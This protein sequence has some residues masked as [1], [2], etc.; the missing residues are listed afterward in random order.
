M[1]RERIEP[2]KGDKRYIRRKAGKFT[3]NQVN[4]GRSLR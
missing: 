3:S 4:I 2:R 1:P